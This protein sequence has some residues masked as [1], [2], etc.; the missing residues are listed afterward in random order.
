MSRQGYRIEVVVQPLEGENP[1]DFAVAV[2]V[3]L[4]GRH[5]GPILVQPVSVLS[6]GE[7]LAGDT[8]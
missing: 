2:A 5:V 6:D 4:D 3:A 7:E 1:S 8:E